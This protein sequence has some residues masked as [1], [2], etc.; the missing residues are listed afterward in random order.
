[1]NPGQESRYSNVL[2]RAAAINNY[3]ELCS[4]DVL[5]LSDI[6]HLSKPD[7]I[8]LEKFKSQLTQHENRCHEINLIWKK[9]QAN[10]KMT[11]QGALVG[12]KIW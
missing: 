1:M 9:D 7:D 10:S 2:L 5:R 11:K 8:V 6:H 12:W 4:L 3:E